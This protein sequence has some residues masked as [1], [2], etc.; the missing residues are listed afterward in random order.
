MS[1][2]LARRT[3]TA[4]LVAL[5]LV[6]AALAAVGRPGPAG[7]QAAQDTEVFSSLGITASNGNFSFGIG[8][9]SAFGVMGIACGGA[10]PRSGG[11]IPA[12]VVTELTPS[13]TLLRVLHNN[14]APLSGAVSVNCT[15]GF[16]PAAPALAKFRALRH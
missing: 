12:Q 2:V 13:A 16:G 1:H 6:A 9:G 15:V 4:G 14:G 10:A 8:S 11:N 5:T 7:A 3:L